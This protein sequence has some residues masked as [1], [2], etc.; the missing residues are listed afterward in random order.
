L[1]KSCHESINGKGYRK[2]FS[3]NNSQ[4]QETQFIAF[5]KEFWE[6]LK[7][8]NETLNITTPSLPSVNDNVFNPIKINEEKWNEIVKRFSSSAQKDMP[9]L[10]NAKASEVDNKK[11]VVEPVTSIKPSENK[12]RATLNN[13]T[14]PPNKKRISIDDIIELGINLKN[15]KILYDKWSFINDLEQIISDQEN[16]ILKQIN[17]TVDKIES[18]LLIEKV[19]NL[20]KVL[21]SDITTNKLN[22]YT[23]Y[24]DALNQLLDE[25]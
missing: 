7:T 20:E 22:E 10:S 6:N 16:S 13:E 18:D 1:L 8:S 4:S 21:T 9:P 11:K 3:A 5:W 24:L 23:K 15:A 19:T 12:K 2:V 25:V 17:K 14:S